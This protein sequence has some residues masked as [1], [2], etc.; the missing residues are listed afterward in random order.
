MTHDLHCKHLLVFALG[1]V[2]CTG[3]IT[4][5]SHGENDSPFRPG[6]IAGATG[7]AGSHAAGASGQAGVS[8]G[9]SGAGDVGRVGIHRL[10]NLEYDNTVRDLLGV[11][12]T[13]ASTFIADEKA[14]GFDSIAD[15]LGM[16]EAQY[17]QYFNA[18]E[19][20][21]DAAFADAALRAPIMLCV[22]SSATDTACTERIVRSFG[23]RAWRRPLADAEIERLTQ[24]AGDALA[25]GESFEGA[26]A[27]VAKAMLASLPFL[28][29]LE[30]DPSPDSSA[31]HPLDA[32]ELASRL[33]YLLWST[34]PDEALFESARSGALLDDDALRAQLTRMLSDERSDA[35]VASFG[36][37]WLGMRELRS[38]QIDREI[39]PEWDEPLREAMINEG[40]AYFSEL[41][42]GNRSMDELFTADV[43]FVDSQLAELY[44]MSGI[45]SDEPVR[46]EDTSDQRRGFLGLASFL[47]LT[48]FSYRTAPTLR[49]RWV[50]ENLLCEHIN[51]P[52]ANVP[53]LDDE[54]EAG[55]DL[56]SLNV[57]E[58]LAMHRENPSCAGCH[59][60]LDPIGLGLESF[61]AIGRY[62]TQYAGGDAVDASGMLPE[63][64][65]F[66]GIMELSALLADDPRLLDCA[67]QKLMT[68]ALSRELGDADAPYLDAIR[69]RWKDEGATLR[70]LLEQIVLSEPF[71]YRHGEEAAP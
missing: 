24:L 19:S 8:G 56:E 9:A 52:P 6:A 12:S 47:T 58:R 71:R 45:S 33:S 55:G 32:Y 28:Y 16:T 25:L 18:S 70:G 7:A 50:L 5:H 61:D 44:G 53:E 54:P 41:L 13:P 38:H 59:V 68:Y 20:L 57:R 51:P 10:N 67:S 3:A 69:A 22:P 60:M 36:G 46:V 39:F 2:A 43:S 48:S 63:G 65:E 35:F 62:R 23:A 11:A 30:L 14:L 27:Q 21:V 29:R 64:D 66:D 17:E 49:G 26:I 34:M 15:A 31:P 40:L 42:R 1:L 37:Q 4:D